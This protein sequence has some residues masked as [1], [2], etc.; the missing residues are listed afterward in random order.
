MRNTLLRILLFIIVLAVPAKPQVNT[1]SVFNRALDDLKMQNKEE[2]L[3]GFLTVVAGNAA[4]DY[5]APSYLFAADLSIQLKNY[6]YAEKYLTDL[7]KQYPDHPFRFDYYLLTAKLNRQKQNKMETLGALLNAMKAADSDSLRKTANDFT[8][9]FVRAEFDTAS[10][11]QVVKKFQGTSSEVY[12]L[13]LKASLF[14]QAGNITGAKEIYLDIIS[15]FPATPEANLSIAALQKAR[16]EPVKVQVSEDKIVAVVLPLTVDGKTNPDATEILN[17]IK[18]AVDEYNGSRKEKAGLWIRDSQRNSEI[19]KSIT[20]EIRAKKDIVAVLGPLYSNETAELCSSLVDLDIPVVSPTA[21]SGDLAKTFE[22]FIQ[23]NPTVDLHAKI[24]ARYMYFVEGVKFAGIFFSNE[25]YSKDLAEIFRAE[26]EGIGGKIIAQNSYSVN[27]VNLQPYIS[28]FSA[29]RGKLQ[30]MYL[31][32][33]DRKSGE[34]ILGAF[35]QDSLFLPFF[36]N[37]DWI[38][39]GA[40]QTSSRASEKF[41][42]TSENFM[43]QTDNNLTDFAKQYAAVMETDLSRYTLYGYDCASLLLGLISQRESANLKMR[44]TAGF[45]ISAFH[46]NYYIGEDR[47][48]KSLNIIKYNRGQFNLVERF[49][50]Q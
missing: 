37:Q 38:N 5:K 22:N 29:L 49:K 21:N 3:R 35:V 30:G 48:N 42:I 28:K 34:Q 17:G 20:D 15:K 2:A 13:L 43:D 14:E 25:G 32:L 8:E 33:S 4:A 41:T 10:F 19:I 9:K 50:L 11:Q 12:V 45:D 40:L 36:G 27:S 6:F 31:P 26:F 16:T 39:S 24:M 7:N 46:N 47:V 18:Y 23:G 44:L 1:D